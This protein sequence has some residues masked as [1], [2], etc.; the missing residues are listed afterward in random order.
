MRPQTAYKPIKQTAKNL[1]I[2]E[3]SG[4]V[5]K[6]TALVLGKI[7]PRLRASLFLSNMKLFTSNSLVSRRKLK[8]IY[9]NSKI[10]STSNKL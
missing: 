9:K 8:D 5:K 2:V 1:L 6:G 10:S 3:K 4:R 7:S